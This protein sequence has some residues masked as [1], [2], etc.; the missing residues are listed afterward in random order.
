MNLG[1]GVIMA[2]NT[3]DTVNKNKQNQDSTLNE[4]SRIE[5]SGLGNNLTNEPSVSYISA[6][7]E[8]VINGTGNSFIILGKDRP[9]SRTSGYGGKGATNSSTIDL[10]VGISSGR[11]SPPKDKDGKIAY[12][13][14]SFILDSARIYISEMTD[15]DENFGLVDGQVGNSKGKSAIALKADGLRFIAR[16]GI[17]LVTKTDLKNSKDKEVVEQ[18]GIDLIANNDDASLQPMVLGTNMVECVNALIDELDNVQNRIQSFIKQQSEYNAKIATHT[19]Y[20][21]FFGQPNTVDPS[22]AVKHGTMTVS[23]LLNVE[24]PYYFQ[25]VNFIGLKQTYLENGEKSIRSK[26]NRVN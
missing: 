19:H 7:N 26:Y 3:N 18:A 24:A 5:Q 16:D 9:A 8:T 11:Q 4:A 1:I 15:V 2:N 22:L 12:S 10:V 6:Q 20:S 21:P 17:K 25:K 23:N 14:K 13:D